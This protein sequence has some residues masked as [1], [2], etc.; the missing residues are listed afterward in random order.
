MLD[1]PLKV[2]P[3]QEIVMAQMDR[4]YVRRVYWYLEHV[5]GCKVTFLGEL[6]GH[7]IEFPA[8][9]VEEVYAGQSTSYTYRTI[10]RFPTGQTLTKYV[11][12][13][14]PAMDKYATMLAFP[15]TLL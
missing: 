4:A 9:T 3:I 6:Q 5:L 11:S 8:G 7:K 15:V 2:S 10:V 14:L 13:I 1:Q 12:A